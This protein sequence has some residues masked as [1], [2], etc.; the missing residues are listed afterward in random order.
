M[1]DAT[2]TEKPAPKAKTPMSAAKPADIAPKSAGS[3][4]K[5]TAASATPAAAATTAKPAVA[6][7]PATAQAKTEQASPTPVKATAP[8]PAKPAAKRKPAAVKKKITTAAKP[9][10]AVEKENVMDAVKTTTEKTKTM[11]VEA[12]VRAK[13]A[14]EK[15]QQMFGEV[16]EFSKGNVEAIV[17]SSKIAAKGIESMGQDTVAYAKKSFEDATATAK[18]LASVKSPTEFMKLQSDF[19]RASF[20][21]MVA[22]TSKSTE[23]MLKLAGDVAQP[24]SN[25]VSLAAEKV[26][27]AA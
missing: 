26:K 11:F 2:A 19:F 21:S 13:A 1:A 4:P 10:P 25:R 16:T 9:A 5:A 22:H 18:Q 3:A 23:A 20:D 8:K 15:S 24:I 7:K 12:N 14:M 27:I 6:A 17:E